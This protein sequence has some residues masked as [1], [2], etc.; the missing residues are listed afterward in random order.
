MRYSLLFS[1]LL[2]FLLS[3]SVNS[4]YDKSTGETKSVHYLKSYK[5][6]TKLPTT[7]LQYKSWSFQ[8]FAI[9]QVGKKKLSDFYNFKGETTERERKCKKKTLKVLREYDIT[10]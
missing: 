4:K 6:L 8:I 5:V 1:F 9:R 10:R 7:K 2:T 3:F